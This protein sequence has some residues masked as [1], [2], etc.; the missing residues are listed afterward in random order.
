MTQCNH[1]REL[2]KV[3]QVHIRCACKPDESEAPKRTVKGRS[4][5]PMK[6]SM[7]QILPGKQNQIDQEQGAP[8]CNCDETGICTCATPRGIVSSS[9]RPLSIPS[10]SDC[11][12]QDQSPCPHSSG[13]P[14]ADSNACCRSSSDGANC[15]S[16]PSSCCTNPPTPQDPLG[17][18]IGLEMPGKSPFPLGGQAPE[19]LQL[20]SS[21][22]DFDVVPNTR[23]RRYNP[24]PQSSHSLSASLGGGRPDSLIYSHLPIENAL[25]PPD[26]AALDAETALWDHFLREGPVSEES[27]SRIGPNSAPKSSA[28]PSSPPPCG[29]AAC[30]SH[31]VDPASLLACAET[32]NIWD[33]STLQA[34][35]STVDMGLPTPGANAQ[36]P[37][38]DS[39]INNLS[40]SN[41]SHLHVQSV[42]DLSYTL[43]PIPASIPPQINGLPTN[44]SVN[45]TAQSTSVTLPT[46]CCCGSTCSCFLCSG[47]NGHSSEGGDCESCSTCD[48]CQIINQ[49]LDKLQNQYIQPRPKPADLGPV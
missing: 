27:A 46:A 49:T 45:P 33:C 26:S 35:I 1:C 34:V 48:E 38:P 9:G 28:P 21:W 11:S 29:C 43:D 12:R 36:T 17:L 10:T 42:P 2:R 24:Y 37:I 8:A 3:K 22:L 13:S 30:A 32:C 25:I 14:G 23:S 15:S 16:S 6:T 7:T 5:I 20:D 19:A 47:S 4:A 39:N 44:A 31:T 18:P 40:A 41:L